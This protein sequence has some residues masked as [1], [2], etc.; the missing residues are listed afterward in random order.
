MYAPNAPSRSSLKYPTTT[1]EGPIFDEAVY[2]A[3]GGEGNLAGSL[4]VVA[5]AGE[6]AGQAAV[7]APCSS[8]ES[9]ASPPWLHPAS[10]IIATRASAMI[11]GIEP[12]LVAGG[13]FGKPNRPPTS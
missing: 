2:V 6:A 8:S 9:L 1:M 7:G 10:P 3:S 4:G 12:P 13:M 5:S 11:L